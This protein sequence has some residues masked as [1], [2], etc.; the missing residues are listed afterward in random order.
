[1][2]MASNG[3][4]DTAKQISRQWTTPTI[5]Q[6]TLFPLHMLFTCAAVFYNFQGQ[7]F[8]LVLGQLQSCT[9]TDDPQVLWNAS[10]ANIR[11]SIRL[12]NLV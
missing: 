12:D 4:V 2:P 1:M 8:C 10:F 5:T 9:S 6:H 7:G 11:R 3:M